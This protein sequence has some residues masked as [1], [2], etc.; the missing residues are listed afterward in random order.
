M[1]CLGFLSWKREAGCN[2][3]AMAIGQGSLCVKLTFPDANENFA[4]KGLIP[5]RGTQPQFQSVLL[6]HNGS[7]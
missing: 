3:S 5:S 4:H 2:E 6:Y 7:V 1:K